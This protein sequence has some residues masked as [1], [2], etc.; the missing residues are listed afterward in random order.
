MENIKELIGLGQQLSAVMDDEEG[1]VNVYVDSRGRVVVNLMPELFLQKFK[2]FN[3]ELKEEEN[4]KYTFSKVVQGVCFTSYAKDLSGLKM[5][6]L[7][8]SKSEYKKS[9][10]ALACE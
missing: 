7:V 8:R 2:G 4:L 1:V 3:I 6:K 10:R 9:L 5:L